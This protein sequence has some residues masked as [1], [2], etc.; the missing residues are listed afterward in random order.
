MRPPKDCGVNP[1]QLKEQYEKTAISLRELCKNFKVSY[2]WLHPRLLRLNTKMK[3]KGWRARKEITFPTSEKFC[4]LLGVLKGDGYVWKKH[5]GTYWIGLSTID[6]EFAEYFKFLLERIFGLFCRM[7]V[8]KLSKR[9]S[10]WHDQ[11]IVETCSAD[12]VEKYLALTIRDIEEIVTSSYELKS[13]FIRGFFDSEGS[14]S[15]KGNGHDL[16]MAN[17]DRELAESVCNI[18]RSLG[19]NVHF[20]H[21]E[22][23][24]PT[25]SSVS[26]IVISD[27]N[28]VH[29]FLEEIKPI[30]RRKTICPCAL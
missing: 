8:K 13:A 27:K 11:F 23:K 26:H 9:N 18:L 2:G 25:W 15:T 12:F 28:E 20:Y 29:R 14:I 5:R 19:Y 3:S 10:N 6:K 16:R 30:I 22:S 1:A 21:Y 24:N 17:T 4:Y 7:R